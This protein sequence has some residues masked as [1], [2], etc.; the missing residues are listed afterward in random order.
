MHGFYI[1]GSKCDPQIMEHRKRESEEGLNAGVVQCLQV[2]G[3]EGKQPR[4]Q[5]HHEKK[6]GKCSDLEASRKKFV[7]STL[8]SWCIRRIS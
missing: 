2:G 1:H 8:K 7:V 4:R 5:R 3:M 6:P